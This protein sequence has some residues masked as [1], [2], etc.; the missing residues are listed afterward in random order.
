MYTA[1]DT[2]S[3]NGGA[4]AKHCNYGYKRVKGRSH[5][6]EKRISMHP[7][8]PHATSQAL[9]LHASRGMKPQGGSRAEE[10]RDTTS[11]GRRMGIEGRTRMPR[12]IRIPAARYLHP[13][14]FTFTFTH[15]LHLHLHL[16]HDTPPQGV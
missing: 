2:P 10:E 4:T 6:A 8:K 11:C 5:T 15:C 13:H 9:Q 12:V 3:R 1:D 7:H 16:H 14:T